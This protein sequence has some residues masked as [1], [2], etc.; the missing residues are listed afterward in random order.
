VAKRGGGY[1]FAIDP[2]GDAAVVFAPRHLVRVLVKVAPAD[3]VVLAD[4]RAAQPGEVRLGLIDAE[5][6]I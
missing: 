5:Q 2:I 1:E 3:P 4:F 6:G